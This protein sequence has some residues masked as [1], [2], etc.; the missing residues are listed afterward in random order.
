MPIDQR[1]RVK[2]SQV[3][4][5]IRYVASRSQQGH[6]V[7]SCEI[8]GEDEI[9]ARYPSSL[10]FN[11]TYQFCRSSQMA[12]LLPGPFNTSDISTP[13]WQT[14]CLLSHVSDL[15]QALACCIAATKSSFSHVHGILAVHS[16]Q[17]TRRHCHE[18][19]REPEAEPLHYFVSPLRLQNHIIDARRY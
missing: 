6:E 12:L 15:I 7:T 2:G 1:S 13:L 8:G 11:R 3:L 19:G 16:C 4:P 9:D 17:G 14:Q 10:S 18:D 5:H